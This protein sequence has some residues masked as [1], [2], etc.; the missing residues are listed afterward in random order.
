MEPIILANGERELRRYSCF[1]G[2][3]GQGELSLTTARL[4]YRAEIQQDKKNF[5]TRRYEVSIKDIRSIRTSYVQTTPKSNN[6]PKLLVGI[7][8]L[9]AAIVCF[10][11]QEPVTYLVGG[12]LAFVGIILIALGCV[13]NPSSYVGCLVIELSGDTRGYVTISPNATGLQNHKSSV[14]FVMNVTDDFDSLQKE[15]GAVWQN[16]VNNK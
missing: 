9:I 15:I 2:A 13:R 8:L 14:S 6:L 4:V 10:C 3:D 7:F 1:S 5:S 16:A 12:I 11:L